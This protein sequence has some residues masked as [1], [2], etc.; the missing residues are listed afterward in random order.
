MNISLTNQLSQYVN[1]K[2][3][4]GLYNS[5]SEV[6]REALRLMKQQ[7]LF[8]EVKIQALRRDIQAGLGSGESTSFD[9]ENI[10]KEAKKRFDKKMS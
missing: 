8:Q 4:S 10:K 1:E 9:P 5:A 6:M 7:D 3:A 2:V